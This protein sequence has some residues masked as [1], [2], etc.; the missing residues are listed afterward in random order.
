MNNDEYLIN[1]T[2]FRSSVEHTRRYISTHNE[3]VIKCV[4]YFLNAAKGIR[5]PG[6]LR[7]REAL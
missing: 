6:L 2:L 5:T 7:D 1:Y 3:T 4:T